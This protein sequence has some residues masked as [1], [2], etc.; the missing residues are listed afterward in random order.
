MRIG[1]IRNKIIGLVLVCTLISIVVT[2]ALS[3]TTSTSI[4]K[5]D[6]Q[7]IMQYQMNTLS[8]ELNSTMNMISQSVDTMA[9]ICLEQITDF[10][11][12]QTDANY[13]KEYT[14]QIEPLIFKF[15]ENTSGAFTCYIRFNPDFTEPTSG[16]FLTRDNADA[17]F[18][19]VTPTDFS[20]YDKDDLEHVG[21]Y[22]IPV[23]NQKP[24]WMD[25]YLNAN[26]NVY[27]ISYVVPIYIDGVSVGIVGMDIDFSK[28]S[29]VA[30]DFHLFDTGY[31][32]LASSSDTILYHPTSEVGVNISELNETG[33][34]TLEETL[35]NG[36]KMFCSVPLTEINAETNALSINIVVAGL[37]SMVLALIL[38]IL[39]SIG[40]V[41]P[42][43]KIT[44]EVLHMADMNFE[45]SAI[46]NK[47]SKKKDET[48]D[49]AKGIATLQKHM[50]EIVNEIDDAR[51]NLEE[52]TNALYITSQKID[53]M[54][55]ENSAVTQELAAGMEQT[56]TSMADVNNNISSVNKNAGE[57]SSLSEK[58]MDTAREVSERAKHLQTSTKQ[59]ISLT[60]ETYEDVRERSLTALEQSKSIDKIKDMIQAITDISSQTNLLALNA[61]IEAAR[62][63]EAGKG[64]AVVAT[65][66]GTLANQT[67]ETV[68]NIDKTVTEAIQAVENM[69]E[70]LQNTT[71]FLEKEVLSGYTGFMDVSNQYANDA[72]EFEKSMDT[73]QHSILELA[74]SMKHISISITEINR[75]VMEGSTGITGIA[76]RTSQITE[77]TLENNHH[78]ENSKDGLKVLKDV[79]E[80]IV[81]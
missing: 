33:N 29:D 32:Y 51:N 44:Q 61:S 71:D 49:I 80:Q 48:G 66:I 41:K 8:T 69:S 15:A 26:I 43:K 2:A 52:N 4:S 77:V 16:L 53:D 6:S 74:E 62:A 11:K 42:L 31:A 28:I 70:C 76:E 79:I 67:L 27:M 58:G 37:I 46:V 21:W 7:E 81:L 19:T 14:E 64:F 40:L 72:N 57:I 45:E 13:V 18:N 65:E 3:I 5:K 20:I 35:V 55:S 54:C 60:K 63:G 56:A 39:F 17:D 73:I 9:N 75:T 59:A 34:S 24:T 36:M 50:N 78:A 47:L 12:F 23:N 22:Y 68:Q 10:E 38:S 25:P 1:N 30:K